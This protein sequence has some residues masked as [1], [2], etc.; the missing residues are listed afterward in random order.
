MRAVVLGVGAVGSRAARQLASTDEVEHVLVADADV[1]RAQQVAAALGDDVASATAAAGLNLSGADVVVLAA[2]AGHR[3]WAERAL[4][5][6]AHVVSVVDD[7]DDM[8]PV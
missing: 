4:E 2:S 1:A 5:H 7:G 6:G 8:G 3:Q